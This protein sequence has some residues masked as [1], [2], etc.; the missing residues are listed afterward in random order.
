MGHLVSY[1]PMNAQ[2]YVAPTTRDDK[3]RIRQRDEGKPPHIT[4]VD[5]MGRHAKDGQPERESIN[6]A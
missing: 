5:D 6:E 1:G 4:Q 2:E 3:Q